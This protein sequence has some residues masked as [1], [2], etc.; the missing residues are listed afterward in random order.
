MTVLRVTVS[1]S[2]SDMVPTTNLEQYERIHEKYQGSSKCAGTNIENALI[3]DDLKYN[4]LPVFVNEKL[5]NNTIC[6]S[7][8]SQ[9]EGELREKTI[10]KAAQNKKRDVLEVE[11]D[12]QRIVRLRECHPWY[13]GLKANVVCCEI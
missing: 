9:K 10:K 13:Y 11:D 1:S 8:D 3:V 6:P 7:V 12:E 2:P 4:D 5:S